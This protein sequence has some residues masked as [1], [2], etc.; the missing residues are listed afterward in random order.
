MASEW[1]DDDGVEWINVGDGGVLQ[2]M[3]AVERRTR[4]LTVGAFGF[5]AAMSRAFTQAAN[6]GKQLDDVLKG[7]ALRLSNMA[8]AQACVMLA[9]S[10]RPWVNRCT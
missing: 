5:G 10:I 2:T 9:C 6:G 3:D 7:V 1:I 8:V 4:S